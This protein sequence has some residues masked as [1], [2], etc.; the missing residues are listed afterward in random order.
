MFT[1]FIRAAVLSLF[2]TACAFAQDTVF[3]S[4]SARQ[5]SPPNRRHS[6]SLSVL[7]TRPQGAFAN[8]VGLGYGV[9]GA[10]LFRLDVAGIWSIRTDVGVVSYGDESRRTPFSESVGGRVEVDVKT[11][12]YIIPVSVGPQLTWPSGVVR[13]YANAGMGAQ[14]FVTESRVDGADNGRVIASTTNHSALAAA[15]LLGGGVYIPVRA[16]MAEIQLDFGAQYVG[17][18]NARYLARGS[19]TDLEDG[20]IRISPLESATRLVIIRAGARIGF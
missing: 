15:W 8:H 1:P 13:P 16:R 18:G 3:A 5:G 14:A 10:Y 12:N 17:G 19:I 7:Q 4:P 2:A 20:R 9:N 11:A 6:A